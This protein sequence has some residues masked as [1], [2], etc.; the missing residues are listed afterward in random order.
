MS[1][2]TQATMAKMLNNTQIAHR[3]G[4][5]SAEFL[6]TPTIGCLTVAF[7][8]NAITMKVGTK[9]HI[10]RPQGNVAELRGMYMH[11]CSTHDFYVLDVMLMGV[12]RIKGKYQINKNTGETTFFHATI[13]TF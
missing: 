1:W 6:N 5:V 7:P 9:L 8:F 4:V 13:K 12:M 3:K 2:Y 10:L 11:S